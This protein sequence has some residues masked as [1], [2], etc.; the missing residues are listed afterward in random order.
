MSEDKSKDKILKVKLPMD[1]P[2]EEGCYLRGNDFSPA[3]VVVLLNNPREQT[4][5]EIEQLVRVAIEN[6]AALAG[7]VQTENIGIE[8]IVSNIVANPNIRYLII[9]GIEVA[10]HNTGDA[11]K[12]LIENGIN[13]RRI[14]VGSKAI[15]PYLFNIPIE[16]I[17]RFRR[18]LTLI[19]LLNEVAPDVVAKAVW[20][21]YQE[22]PTAFQNYMLHDP[23]ACPEAAICSKITLRI[24]KP[25]EIE[26]WEIDDILKGGE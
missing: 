23:G 18:Q 4:P 8:K 26:D 13:D 17:K 2:P 19:N 16:S 7:T 1:Y 21:C 15:T 3:A 10:G 6:G 5:L 25:Q 20:S 9:C 11:L 14:I 24:K 12:C 22:E